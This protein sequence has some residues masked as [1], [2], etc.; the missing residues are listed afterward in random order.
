MSYN[1]TENA[2]RLQSSFFFSS[3][4]LVC[5]QSLETR[6]KSS[7]S[8]RAYVRACACVCV[9]HYWLIECDFY[10]RR[11]TSVFCHSSGPSCI[12]STHR[13][14]SLS[15]HSVFPQSWV[16]TK[17]R[18]CVPFFSSRCKQSSDANF[19]PGVI[20]VLFFIAFLLPGNTV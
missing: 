8:L 20:G 15:A 3:S 5:E 7:F 11:D 19:R 16:E 12:F 17:V 9:F 6:S 13:C 18:A 1:D 4:F 14:S 10:C 2:F